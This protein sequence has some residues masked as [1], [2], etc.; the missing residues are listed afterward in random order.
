MGAKILIADDDLDNRTIAVETLE[1]AGYGVVTAANGLEAIDQILKE[2]PALVFLDLS[3]PKMSGWQVAERIKKTPGVSEIPLIAF[4]AHALNGDEQK[5][6]AAGCDDFLT[7]PCVPKKMI[8][9]VRQWIG[10][11]SPIGG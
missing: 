10:E 8:E 11:S 2:R 5:A 7:K 4:T 3:M 1:A 9:K 6:R